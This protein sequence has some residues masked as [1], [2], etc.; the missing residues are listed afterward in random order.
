[1]GD[2]NSFSYMMGVS[3]LA[4]G[5]TSLI[6][7]SNQSKALEAQ[8]Q[9]QQKSYDFNS[10]LADLQATD[11]LKRGETDAT[12]YKKGIVKTIGAQRASMAAQGI[13]LDSGSAL[14]IQQ[15]TAHIGEQDAMTIRNN[16]AREAWGYKVQALDYTTKGQ[17]AASSSQFQAS[18]T[19]LTGNLEALG[20]GLKGAS[21]FSGGSSKLTVPTT[22]SGISNSKTP[23]R[24]Y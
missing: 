20:Y 24:E 23:G 6:S 1:M 5:G 19:M 16:A 21:Y 13:E 22:T 9:F 2:G 18:S 17:F 12:N 3:S 14:E 4:Q 15:D 11:A 8:G 10:K 7:A